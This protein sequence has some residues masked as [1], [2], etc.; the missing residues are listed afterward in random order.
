MDVGF[1]VGEPLSLAYLS[2]EEV[3]IDLLQSFWN[4]GQS[5]IGKE[6]EMLLDSPPIC[7]FS[8]ENLKGAGISIVIGLLVYF[9]VVRTILVKK[10]EE[11]AYCN[12][13]SPYADLENM[14][15]RPL[16]LYVLP[17]AGYFVC[18][19]LDSIIAIV[20]KLRI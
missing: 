19:V 2:A 20:F 9:L 11:N 5:L 3:G 18:R 17:F 7:W 8:P 14:L 4:Q 13:L 16:L 6:H 12:R 15:Y 10:S 1:P